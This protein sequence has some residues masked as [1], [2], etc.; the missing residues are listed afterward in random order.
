MSARLATFCLLLAS[1]SLAAAASPAR[2]TTGVFLLIRTGQA[3]AATFQN[4]KKELADLMSPAGVPVHWEEPSD[5]HVVN[6]YTIVVDLSGNCTVPFHADAERQGLG[7][8][9]GSTATADGSILPFVQVNCGALAS[10]IAPRI[11]DQPEFL[12][13]FVLGRALAR[14]LAH[15][16]YHILTQSENHADSGVA[17]AALSVAD[18][19][20]SRLEF[21][22]AT[23]GRI[24]AS[25][26]AGRQIAPFTDFQLPDPA[27]HGSTQQEPTPAREE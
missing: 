14:V 23:L 18:L 4:M 24:Q 19:I 3:P 25:R 26:G 11:E 2:E 8:P 15:E 5:F 16:L 7:T 10:L 17:K 20:G 13:E 1:A 9:L 12:R 27:P 21:D 22:E 6:G